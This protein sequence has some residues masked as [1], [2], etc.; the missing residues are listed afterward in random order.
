MTYNRSLVNGAKRS[1]GSRR[2]KHAGAVFEQ[3]LEA[4]CSIYRETG[5]GV[6]MRAHPPT[7]GIP[8]QMFFTAKGGVDFVGR[9]G[10]LPVAF[11]AKNLTSCDPESWHFADRDLHQAVWLR[12]FA[13]EQNG[14]AF[15]ILC[16]GDVAYMLFD[17][18]AL[19]RGEAVRLRG[20]R[21]P[22]RPTERKEPPVLVPTVRRSFGPVTWDFL[23]VIKQYVL[24][25]A[26]GRKPDA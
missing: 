1:I 15:V 26:G 23:P 2:A 16:R 24:S 10:P 5:L 6:F 25:L 9:Y 3:E 14:V 12:D 8:G 19:A 18:N 21:S 7:G 13:A 4:T 20:R 22:G 17:V 11:D